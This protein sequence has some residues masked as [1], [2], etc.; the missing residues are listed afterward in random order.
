MRRRTHVPRARRAHIRDEALRM[1]SL[2]RA[3]ARTTG[4]VQDELRRVF[5]G[6]LEPGEARM[7]AE[8]WAVRNVREGLVRLSVGAGL[9]ASHLVDGDVWRW[10]RGEVYPR[11]WLE[12]LCR[13]FQCHQADLGWPA[14]GNDAPI[15]FTAR[16]ESIDGP[17][18]DA[19]ALQPRDRP[20]PVIDDRVATDAAPAR[21]HPISRV[22]PR[23]LHNALNQISDDLD[24]DLEEDGEWQMVAH[25]DA[26]WSDSALAWLIAPA[27]GPHGVGVRRIGSTDIDALR[28]TVGVLD[29]LDHQFGGG[30]ARKLLIQY[31]ASDVRSM[32]AGLY[33][34]DIAGALFS[35]AA[36]GI[37]L[38]A[39]MS[40]DSGLHGIAQRYFMYS[41]R[42]AQAADD[43]ALGSGIL[44]A[45]SQQANFL[46]ADSDA[47]DLAR[48]AIY[49]GA[50][51]GSPTVMALCHAKE[52]RSLAARGDEPGCVAA[53]RQA[54]SSFSRQRPGDDPSWIAYFDQAE[55]AA[56]FA[57][58]FRDLDQPRLSQE[59]ASQALAAAETRYVRSLLFIRLL[60]ATSYAQAREPE[61][62][63]ATA[64]EA[65]RLSGRLKSSRPQRYIAEFRRRLEP[66][67]GTRFVEDF[68][69]CLPEFPEPLT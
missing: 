52:A 19:L 21:R 33:S 26:A 58:C 11:D 67:E 60:L 29:R 65:I 1:A 56:E 4:Q 57:H 37:L 20:S 36:E 51:K 44:A 34:D 15:D 63:C 8:G 43:R 17:P 23:S 9:D 28:T 50:S 5:A 35:A 12:R 53:L 48:A 27:D 49:G 13:L 69:D 18:P 30:H 64:T 6:E 41:L 55:L 54:E 62:A 32:L 16:H 3:E 10:L 22:Y 47:T 14:R 42:L 68:N 39:W 66:Y 2:G 46:R 25:S 7:Y 45:M 40:Y 38:A 24:A 59:Y 31:L 61:R